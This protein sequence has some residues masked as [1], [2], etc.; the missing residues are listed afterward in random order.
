MFRFV[1]KG[2]GSGKFEVGIIF[3]RLCLGLVSILGRFR[4]RRNLEMY[5]VFGK[6]MK[7]SVTESRKHGRATVGIEGFLGSL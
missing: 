2:V 6:F 7:I 4:F 5:E 3:K 1:K